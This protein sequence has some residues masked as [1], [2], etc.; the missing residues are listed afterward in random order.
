MRNDSQIETYFSSLDFSW[1]D[2]IEFLP[3]GV[4]F[5]DNNWKIKSVNR[6]FTV[7]FENELIDYKLEG[8]NLFSKNILSEK[9]PLNDVLLLKAGKYFE[10]LISLKS[11]SGK[12]ISLIF[13]GSPIFKDSVFQGGT[14]IVEDYIPSLSKTDEIPITSCSMTNFLS[15]IC[16]CFLIVDLGGVVQLV[17]GTNEAKCSFLKDKEGR[18]ISELFNLDSDIPLNNTLKQ[19]INENKAHSIELAYFSDK[20]KIIFNSVFLPFTNKMDEVTSVVILIR[21]INSI[22]EDSISSLSNFA[23]LREFESFANSSA[24]GL[25]KI[26]LLGNI[27]Y[28]AEN[29]SKLFDISENEITS[30]FIDQ[31]FPEVNQEYFEQIRKKLLNNGIW[32]GYLAEKDDTHSNIIKVKIISKEYNNET[33]LYVYCDKIDHHQQKIISAREEEKLFFKDAVIKSNQMIIQTNPFGTILFTNEKFCENFGYGLDEIR[34]KLFTDLIEEEFRLKKKITDFELSINIKDFEV[35]PLVSKS[36]E[37]IEVYSNINIYTSNTELKYFTIYL[38]DYSL[39]DKLFLETAHALLYQFTEA[40]IIIHEDKIIKVNPKFCELFGSEFETDYF[41]LS[42]NEIIDT[43][44]A[45]SFQFLLQSGSVSKKEEKI[46]FVKNDKSKFEANT[47]KICCTKESS[48]SVLIIQPTIEDKHVLTDKSDDIKKEFDNIG[49]IL[50]SGIL[51]NNELKIDY[52]SPEIVESTGYPQNY[53]ISLP[54]LLK[55]ITHPDDIDKVS[56]ELSKMYELKSDITRKINYRIISKDGEVSW[57]TNKIKLFTENSDETRA[58]FGSISD[59]TD[60]SLEKEELKSIIDEL[61]ILNSAK[62]KFISIISHDLKSPFTSIVGFS[63]LILTDPTLEKEEIIEFVGNIKDASLHTVDLLNG[64]LDLTKLQTGRI[65]VEPRIINANYITNKTVEILSGL[66]FQKGLS[67][68]SNVDKSFYINADENLIFQVFNNLV[69]N[70][71]KF[72]P[73]GGSI[74]ISA[75]ELPDQQKIEFTIKDSGVGID[76]EDIE[77]LFVLDKKFTTLGTEGERGTGLGL[78]LVIEIIEKHNGKISVKSELNKGSEFIFTLPISTPS[79]LILDGIQSDRV[80]YGRLLESITNSIEIIP[81][82]NE[83]EAIGIVKEQMPML[84][85]FEHNLPN[86]KGDE[87]LEELNKAGLVYKPSLMVLSKEYNEELESFYKEIGVDAVFSKPFDLKEFK[88]QLDKLT[89]R[90][91]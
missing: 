35:L 52:I 64:L 39:K 21:D 44:S 90:I 3:V 10:K 79:I 53:F 31:V 36:G 65:D 71:I 50:W 26:N 37:I 33:N 12:D 89:G 60:W 68:V 51:E 88:T 47:K 16:K 69:A 54:N 40:V 42:I 30:K 5:L 83:E 80:L 85:I 34:G 18:K 20:E 82:D 23:K 58:V 43:E 78:S 62:E 14:L 75:K 32:E 11:K 86:M 9:L 17:S 15:K 46:T 77:K 6:N 84:I 59:V 61:H 73:K 28:W 72:T 66:A 63:E 24:D 41:D 22:E 19:S 29:A 45:K 67:F 56:R 13:R 7:F 25:F 87:F 70:S 91:A 55:E 74:E 38:R 81:S 49:P 4:I 57:I 27:T 48:F 8:I 76:K 1:Q 2:L